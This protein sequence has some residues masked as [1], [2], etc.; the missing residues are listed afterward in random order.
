MRSA[1]RGQHVL[2]EERFEKKGVFVSPSLRKK[3]LDRGS[4]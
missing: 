3:I 1:E 4:L 2:G